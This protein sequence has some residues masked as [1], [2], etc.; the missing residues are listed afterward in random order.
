MPW[1][2]MKIGA[3]LLASQGFRVVMPDFL[4]GTYCTPDMF[5]G[6]EAYVFMPASD[7]QDSTPSWDELRG[8]SLT[9]G[10]PVECKS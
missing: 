1:E 10:P 4:K 3:D 6:T 5:D 7:D 9:I 2:L 8:H